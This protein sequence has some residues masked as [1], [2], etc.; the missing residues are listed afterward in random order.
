[1]R[2][3][4]SGIQ[5][6]AK[7]PEAFRQ[8]YSLKTPTRTSAA[9]SYGTVVHFALQTYHMNDRDLGL[10]KDTFEHYWLHPEQMGCAPDYYLPRTSWSSYRSM[11]L[12]SL[13][14]Y[15]EGQRWSQDEVI[16]LEVPFKL[17]IGEH[18]LSGIIDLVRI[19]YDSKGRQVLDVAD[20]KTGKK[21]Y[22]LRYNV[23]FTAYA[24]AASR[25]EFWQQVPDGHRWIDRVIG[26]PITTTWISLKDNEEIDAGD[27]VEEDFFRLEKTIAALARSV[28]QEIYVPTL[29]GDSCAYCEFWKECGLPDGNLTSKKDE[30][31]A[32]AEG[33]VKFLEW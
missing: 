26:L 15:H 29:S 33:P 22:F 20:F 27:R 23:Q 14:A 18:E 30:E 1:M 28:D 24:W 31:A 2:V 12:S 19:K 7:C 6:F 32:M 5:L 16:G 13:A 9:M 17:P 8:K 11:G 3:S 4:Q 10:A 21:P 25:E